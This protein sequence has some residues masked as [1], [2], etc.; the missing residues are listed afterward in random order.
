MKHSFRN[1]QCIAFLFLFTLHGSNNLSLE[2]A[3]QI[4]LDQLFLAGPCF[5]LLDLE[6]DSNNGVVR[7]ESLT[8]LL[9]IQL[10]L[11]KDVSDSVLGCIF[12]RIL[13]AK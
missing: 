10:D 6:G 9:T 11:S 1:I 12:L 3:V 8:V 5:V 2:L 4:V 7:A 13:H